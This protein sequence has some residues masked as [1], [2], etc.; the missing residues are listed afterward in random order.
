MAEKSERKLAFLVFY[1]NGDEG[2]E[3]GRG[4]FS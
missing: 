4:R 1:E 3:K 2:V